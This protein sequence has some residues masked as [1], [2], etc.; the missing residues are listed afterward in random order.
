MV[1]HERVNPDAVGIIGICGWGG[2]ALN[3]AASDPRIKATLTST[4][5]DMTRVTAN[6][7]FDA[8]NSKEKRDAARK[9]LADQRT[10]D[11]QSG[12]YDFAGG[13]ADPVTDDMP[14]FVKDYNSF[15]KNPRGY[16]KRSLGS[17][18]GF[19]KTTSITFMNN[20][21]LDYINELDSAVLMI[22][23]ANAHSRYFSEGAFEK[24]T[25]KHVENENA[26]VGNKELLIIPD[27]NHVDLYDNMDK[28][29]FDKIE[30]FFGD[31]L[32]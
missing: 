29:P 24:M 4:M 32:K 13:V 6:G 1:S 16:H 7:Y 31:N 11:Y 23:G 3:A 10:K 27:A 2:F 12:S 26:T 9:A 20:K 19:T 17:T 5:Y 30:S 22:H 8:D 21:L 14:Q 25:G 28:I 18:T 15:Y